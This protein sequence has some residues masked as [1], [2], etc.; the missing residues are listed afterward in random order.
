MLL[1]TVLR[2]TTSSH[3]LCAQGATS[4]VYLTR[5]QPF[6]I[7]ISCVPADRVLVF[8]EAKRAHLRL[9]RDASESLAPPLSL[10]WGPLVAVRSALRS[11]WHQRRPVNGFGCCS[12]SR[13][14]LTRTLVS[15]PGIMVVLLL[16]QLISFVDPLYSL[17]KKTA[18]RTNKFS[19]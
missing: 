10:R 8:V 16:P 11:V 12:R 6:K 9:Y 1:H 14:H 7:N 5:A 13:A 4:L 15:L 2:N 3:V 19:K 18:T 17:L